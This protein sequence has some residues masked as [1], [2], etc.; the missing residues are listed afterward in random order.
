M[1][2]KSKQSIAQ[3]LHEAQVMID[4][5]LRD[6]QIQERV[7][8]FGFPVGK[9]N[10]AKALFEAAQAAVNLQILKSGAQQQSTSS[11]AEAEVSARD[12]YRALAKVAR[13]VFIKDK[14][15]LTVLGLTGREPDSFAGFLAAAYTL[16]NNAA[17][18][19]V[20]A[21]YGYDAAK[22][23]TERGKIAALDDANLRQESA[24]G[25][26][27]QSTEERDAALQALHNWVSQYRQIARVALRDQKQLLESIGIV[28]RTSRGKTNVAGE[29]GA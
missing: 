23:Q 6:P 12:A 1:A 13:A 8:A 25:A 3:Q 9:L 20:L 26:A 5:S 29:E 28:V 18:L 14:G 21:E 19:S 24:K 4:N 16:F 10:A 2:T 22:L 11:L 27:Q 7:A 17:N 15:Q